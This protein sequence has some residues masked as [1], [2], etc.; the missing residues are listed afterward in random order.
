MK[1]VGFNGSVSASS[2]T[3][4]GVLAVLEACRQRGAETILYDLREHPLPF[5]DPDDHSRSANED[6][7]RFTSLLTEADGIVLGSPEYHNTLGGAFKN[8]MDWVGSRQFAN[9]P[10]A[11][12]SATGGPSSMPTLTAMQL[13]I[14][15]LH[16]WIVPVL[17]SIPGTAQFDKNGTFL[18]PDLK[19]RFDTIGSELVRMAELLKKQ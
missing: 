13:M 12:V 14:R 6:V 5:Y 2:N 8:A 4:K 16:G 3:R 17:G 19:Q 1:I 18:D 7:R 9:K 10:V 11:L 15:S